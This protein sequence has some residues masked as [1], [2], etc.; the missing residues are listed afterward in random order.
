[1]YHHCFQNVCTFYNFY[2]PLAQYYFAPPFQHCILTTPTRR[3]LIL[4]WNHSTVTCFTSLET[5]E[6]F[7]LELHEIAYSFSCW[8]SLRLGQN[9]HRQSRQQ[10]V[11]GRGS[12]PYFPQ[13]FHIHNILQQRYYFLHNLTENQIRSCITDIRKYNCILASSM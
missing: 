2:C 4:W 3:R 6:V 1:M 8:R 11:G 10:I 9:I 13:C 5:S 7:L 12:Q